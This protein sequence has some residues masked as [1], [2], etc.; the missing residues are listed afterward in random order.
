V[1]GLLEIKKFT[2]TYNDHNTAETL[3]WLTLFCICDAITSSSVLAVRNFDSKLNNY[4]VDFSCVGLLILP[5]RLHDIY[6][7]KGA[8][9]LYH[10]IFP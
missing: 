4:Y 8:G 2:I 5:Y 7:L 6:A 10:D 9:L 3:S 1:T